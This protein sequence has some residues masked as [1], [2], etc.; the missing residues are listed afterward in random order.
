MQINRDGSSMRA[1]TS[2][3]TLDSDD[4]SNIN[5]KPKQLTKGDIAKMKI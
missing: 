2:I 4:W 3:R 1:R 5:K